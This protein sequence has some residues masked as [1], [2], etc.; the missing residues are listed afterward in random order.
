MLVLGT[1]LVYAAMWSDVGYRRA[2]RRGW[3]AEV[4]DKFWGGHFQECG[5]HVSQSQTIKSNSKKALS[6]TTIFGPGGQPPRCS[7]QKAYLA[8]ETAQIIYLQVNIQC[9]TTSESNTLLA[10][11]LQRSVMSSWAPTCTWRICS[12]AFLVSYIFQRTWNVF[13]KTCCR[14]T[15]LMV[16]G[17]NLC[18][19]W[20]DAVWTERL[21]L[22]LLPHFERRVA[23]KWIMHHR[24]WQ[25]LCIVVVLST[26]VW[27]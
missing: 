24:V 2:R 4:Q 10:D 7:T 9:Q 23:D 11:G 16:S 13:V 12:F 1:Y 27:N 18:L 22:H 17:A 3:R 20:R 19:W 6:R 14:W 25:F 26:F 5:V 15:W 8:I 21:T